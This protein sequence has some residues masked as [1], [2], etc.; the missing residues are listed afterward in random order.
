M[1]TPQRADIVFAREPV[2]LIDREE[3]VGTNE[4][5]KHYDAKRFR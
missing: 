5:G 2:D 3:A 1:R 4:I